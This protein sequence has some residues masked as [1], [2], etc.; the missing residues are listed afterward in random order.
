MTDKKF[1]EGLILKAKH[2]RAPEY[3]LCKLSI[4]RDELIAWLTQQDGEWINADIKQSQAGKLYAQVDDW[5]PEGR[6]QE[7]PQRTQRSAPQRQ[8]PPADDFREDDIPW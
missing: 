7:A 4:K 6:R 2:E 1:I 8:A 5:K 3:V